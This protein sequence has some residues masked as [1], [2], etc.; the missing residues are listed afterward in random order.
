MT[1]PESLLGVLN[2]EHFAAMAEGWLPNPSPEP[3][4]RIPDRSGGDDDPD[5]SAGSTTARTYRP[6]DST[7]AA[8]PACPPRQKRQ[9]KSESP[10]DAASAPQTK[11]GSEQ[12]PQPRN[13]VDY[14]KGEPIGG[15]ENS[16]D[17]P[18]F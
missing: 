18:P 3:V 1:I 16:I 13:V 17:P 2:A 7:P 5:D 10:D 11:P 8:D 14:V 12:K 15:W 6:A 9:E 4:L